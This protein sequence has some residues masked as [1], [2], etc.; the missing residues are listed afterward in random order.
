MQA[1]W[2][3]AAI[4]IS[5]FAALVMTRVFRRDAKRGLCVLNARLLLREAILLAGPQ[6][7]ADHTGNT[8]I[9]RLGLWPTQCT[10]SGSSLA[11]SGNL[12]DCCARSTCKACSGE[13][14]VAPSNSS[15]Y[16]TLLSSVL[17]KR[18]LTVGQQHPCCTAVLHRTA[19]RA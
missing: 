17:C 8:V 13:Q 16:Y 19:Q 7:G 15:Y 4:Q 10:L 12:A 14:K 18:R 1:S 9:Y 6:L 3:L 11:W 2:T 5:P